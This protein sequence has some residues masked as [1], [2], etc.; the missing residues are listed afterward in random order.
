LQLVHREVEMDEMLRAGPARPFRAQG[1][2][3]MEAEA[4]SGRDLFVVAKYLVPTDAHLVQGCLAA[5]GIPAVV[6]DDNH[7]QA[8]LLLSPALGG[9]RV[10][11]PE[12][13]LRQAQ[14]ILAAFERG[15]FELDDDADVGEP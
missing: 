2:T 5:A 13:F 6:A 7:V 4:P 10:L 11:V 15:E 3:D 8:N 12:V 9:V 1:E 14:E